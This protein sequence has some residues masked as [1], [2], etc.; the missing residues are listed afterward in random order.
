VIR[1]DGLGAHVFEDANATKEGPVYYD[2][3]G[4]TKHLVAEIIDPVIYEEVTSMQVLA[5]VDLGKAYVTHFSA[6]KKHEKKDLGGFY[7]TDGNSVVLEDKY[8]GTMSY[9]PAEEV[10]DALK[11][12]YEE[13]KNYAALAIAL[14]TL[15]R[16]LM[17]YPQNTLF[18]LVYGY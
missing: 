4:D 7:A 18:C 12:D 14:A 10:Y 6:L 3:D 17:L 15:Q 5:M 1:P 9:I 13:H 16:A 11:R 8:G 2:A